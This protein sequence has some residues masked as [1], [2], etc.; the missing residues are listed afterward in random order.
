MESEYFAL[1]SKLKL[2]YVNGSKRREERINLKGYSYL[3]YLAWFTN[4]NQ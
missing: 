2:N 4:D 3:H 1:F